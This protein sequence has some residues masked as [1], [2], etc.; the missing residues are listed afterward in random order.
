MNKTNIICSVSLLSTV[1]VSCDEKQKAPGQPNIIYIL[2]D[3]LGYG[4]LGC[5]GQAIIWGLG[6][7]ASEGAPENQ[8]ID[9]FFGYICQLSKDIR[10]ENNIVKQHPEIVAELDQIM[11]KSRTDSQIF[12]FSLPVAVN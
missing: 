2:A 3:D 1:V 6:N 12:P 11:R 8:G 7:P 4:D 9:E 10:E 5:Y